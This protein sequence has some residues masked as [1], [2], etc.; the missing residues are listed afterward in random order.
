M[1]R[2]EWEELTPHGVRLHATIAYGEKRAERLAAERQLQLDIQRT[3][4]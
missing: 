4:K 2:E 1:L 3:S